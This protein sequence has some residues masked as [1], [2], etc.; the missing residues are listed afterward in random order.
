MTNHHTNQ[1][2]DPHLHPKPIDSNLRTFLGKN[3]KGESDYWLIGHIGN[4]VFPW[5]SFSISAMAR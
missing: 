4:S 3:K 1:P 2:E 5:A